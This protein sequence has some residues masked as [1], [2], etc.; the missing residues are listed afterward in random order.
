M[1]SILIICLATRFVNIKMQLN[2]QD[3]SHI[4]KYYAKSIEINAQYARINKIPAKLLT[5]YTTGV[6]IAPTT[7]KVLT[8]QKPLTP[9]LFICLDRRDYYD[10]GPRNFWQYG[11]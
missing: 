6:I 2:H 3:Y 5:N 4:T 8:V 11:I 9:F 7:A 1:I 10:K